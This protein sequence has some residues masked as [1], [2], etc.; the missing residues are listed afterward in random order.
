M[1]ASL[2]VANSLN[3]LYNT[4]SSIYGLIMSQIVVYFLPVDLKPLNKEN[5]TQI[6]DKGDPIHV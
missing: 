1:I 2:E 6:F 4:S 3:S 5:I